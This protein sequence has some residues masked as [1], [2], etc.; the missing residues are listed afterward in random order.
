MEN[1]IFFEGFR[2]FVIRDFRAEMV[3]VMKA[4]VAGE[5]LEEPGKL[6]ERAALQADAGV[7]P[8]SMPDPPG[9]IEIVLDIE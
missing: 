3:D 1:W 6:I 5:P 4:N 8:L 9:T 2:Q 7:I